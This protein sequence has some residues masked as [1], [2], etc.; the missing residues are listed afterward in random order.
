MK[1]GFW[2]VLVLVLIACKKEE[3]FVPHNNIEGTWTW[4]S[5]AK[6]STFYED[7]ATSSN[8]QILNLIDYKNIEWKRNDT[9]YYSGIYLYAIKE[10][11]TL[12]TNKWIMDLSGIPYGF[13]LNRSA[14]TLWLQEDRVD[15]YVHRFLRQ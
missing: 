4:I 1:I 12:G 3:D 8:N 2:G 9:V 13:M 10:S 7:T 5:T 11:A 14:D 15:G 6:D